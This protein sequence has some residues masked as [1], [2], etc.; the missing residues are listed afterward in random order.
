MLFRR[1]RCSNKF[2]NAACVIIRK[3]TDHHIFL[4]LPHSQNQ[5]KSLK[6]I[7]K[8]QKPKKRRS[9]MMCSKRFV[10]SM[11]FASLA[12]ALNSGDPCSPIG[13]WC[14]TDDNCCSP[15]MC[16]P[17]KGNHKCIDPCGNGFVDASNNEECEPPNTATC[18]D[19]CK[20]I[21]PRRPRRVKKYRH[22][23]KEECCDCRNVICGRYV[24]ECC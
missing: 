19:K 5:L 15:L 23:R 7:K 24:R 14:S 8:K 20:K 11:M 13:T 3:N 17:E 12:S 6:N 22:H 18:D 9:T 16:N 21:K 2:A 10:A 4:S 1:M